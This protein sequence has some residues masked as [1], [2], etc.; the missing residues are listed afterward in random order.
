MSISNSVAVPSWGEAT[1][2]RMAPYAARVAFCGLLVIAAGVGAESTSFQEIA[3]AVAQA[4]PDW[5]HLLRAMA[6]L[7]SM[8]AVAAAAAVVWRLASPAKPVWLALYS[9][10]GMAMMAGPGLIWG[11]AHI[12][13]GALLLHAGLAATLALLWRDPRVGTRLAAL[14]R[15]RRAAAAKNSP[16]RVRPN[17]AAGR[18]AYTSGS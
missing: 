14:V 18:K 15:A 17:C 5:A 2:L 4:G 9:L 10:A 3:R 12:G 7:K 16:A 11:L 6:A 13:L 1:R 8:M